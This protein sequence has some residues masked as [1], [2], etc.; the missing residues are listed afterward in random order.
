MRSWY[1]VWKGI[2]ISILGSIIAFFIFMVLWVLPI[3]IK[4]MSVHVEDYKTNKFFTKYL[5]TF[6][7]K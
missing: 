6:L 1:L 3:M 7:I 4:A 2:G 5:W